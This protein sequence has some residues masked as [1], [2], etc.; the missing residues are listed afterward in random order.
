MTQAGKVTQYT[1]PTVFHT[2]QIKLTSSGKKAL[3][4]DTSVLNV[5]TVM[6]TNWTVL[7]GQQPRLTPGAVDVIQEDPHGVTGTPKTSSGHS[8]GSCGK[9]DVHVVIF[10]TTAG[11]Y[12]FAPI[13][14]ISSF[15]EDILELGEGGGGT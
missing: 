13:L 15:K 11:G 2:V 1:P 10:F 4:D 6:L 9:G 5:T 12:K 7:T 3:T 14:T 8:D